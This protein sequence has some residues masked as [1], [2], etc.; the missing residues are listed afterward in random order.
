M[1]KQSAAVKIY[2]FTMRATDKTAP[3]M[4][5]SYLIYENNILYPRDSTID[6]RGRFTIAC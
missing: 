5:T 3:S 2:E 1:A 4:H 6:A